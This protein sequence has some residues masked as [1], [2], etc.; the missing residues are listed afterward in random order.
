MLASRFIITL[1]DEVI[2]LSPVH[3]RHHDPE[4]LVGLDVGGSTN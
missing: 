1:A 4:T 3:I 2:E